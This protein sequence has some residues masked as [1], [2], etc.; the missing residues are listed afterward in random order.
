MSCRRSNAL[1]C[2]KW[3]RLHTDSAPE[4]SAQIRAKGCRRC[5]T[6][7][8]VNLSGKRTELRVIRG[9]YL[10]AEFFCVE[11]ASFFVCFS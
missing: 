1:R 5:K 11:K 4:K 9:F 3:H 8:L 7:F 6:G 10:L 2:L